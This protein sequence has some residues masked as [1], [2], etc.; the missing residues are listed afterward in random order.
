MI[1]LTQE[2]IEVLDKFLG[3]MNYYE[4]MGVLSKSYEKDEIQSKRNLLACTI[5]KVK[6]FVGKTDDDI[7]KEIKYNSKRVAGQNFSLGFMAGAAIGSFVGV[8][9]GTITA[10]LW[11]I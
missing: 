7:N 6:S 3:N 4:T 8:I 5:L 1:N 11:K 9:A 2:E 10:D